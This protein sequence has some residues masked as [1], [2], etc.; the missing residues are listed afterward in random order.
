VQIFADGDDAVFL[1][2]AAARGF[3][4]HGTM[5]DTSVLHPQ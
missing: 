1:R 5:I 3:F 2:K 4:R